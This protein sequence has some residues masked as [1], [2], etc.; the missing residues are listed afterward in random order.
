MQ[1]TETTTEGL[2]REFRVVVPATDLEARLNDRLVQLKDRVRLNGF[3]PG[4]VPVDASQEGLWPRRDGG[5]DR[6][7]RPRD[8]R[9]DRHR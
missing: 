3:R 9:Q 5:D 7:A 2:K 6:G 1:V 8:Q 4:K